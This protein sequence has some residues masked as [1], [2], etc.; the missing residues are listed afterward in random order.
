MYLYNEFSHKATENILIWNVLY[1][2]FQGIFL[3]DSIQKFLDFHSE[4][5]IYNI[6]EYLIFALFFQLLN[7]ECFH[8]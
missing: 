5:C 6:N 4:S 2:S 1:P 8:L 3:N 7:L